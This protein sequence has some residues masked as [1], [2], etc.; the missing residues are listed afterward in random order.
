MAMVSEKFLDISCPFSFWSC[1]NISLVD[2]QLFWAHKRKSHHVCPNCRFDLK[3]LSFLKKLEFSVH[4]FESAFEILVSILNLQ[5]EE[6][7]K[8]IL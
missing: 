8:P 2:K 1:T 7:C 5:S 6:E 3:E 4:D